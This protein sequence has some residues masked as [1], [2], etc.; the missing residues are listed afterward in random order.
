[1]VLRLNVASTC[2]GTPALG[3]GWRSVVWVQGC[4]FRC[5]GCVAPE[6]IPDVPARLAGVGELAGELLA[7]E[8]VDGLTFSG[9]EPMAQ[10][11]GLAALARAAREVRDVSVVCFTGFTLPRLKESGL[12]G[13][14]ELLSEVDV[15]IDGQYVRERDDGL[16]LRGSTNQVVHHLTGRLADVGYDFEGRPRTAEVRV[17]EREVAL[18]GVPTADLLKRLAP[19]LGGPGR[20]RRER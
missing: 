15:L 10:A 2:V 5:R 1:M 6:W 12:P 11:E 20:S 7:D 18:V 4:P 14:A 9:G 13:V 19:V 17:G 3:P 16:G 8:R